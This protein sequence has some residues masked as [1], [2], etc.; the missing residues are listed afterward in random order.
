MIPLTNNA[1][2]AGTVHFEAFMGFPLLIRGERTTTG[3]RSISADIA[4]RCKIRKAMSPCKTNQERLRRPAN[5]KPIVPM[6]SSAM[7]EG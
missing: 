1:I 5:S 3:I 6:A 7:V 4:I 2:A